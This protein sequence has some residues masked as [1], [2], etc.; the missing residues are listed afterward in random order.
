MNLTD[1]EQWIWWEFAVYMFNRGVVIV[2]GAGV[3][4][5]IHG[6]GLHIDECTTW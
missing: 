1:L 2:S 6:G 3:M 5:C 4:Q